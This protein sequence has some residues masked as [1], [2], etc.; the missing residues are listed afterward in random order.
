MVKS[1]TNRIEEPEVEAHEDVEGGA[2]V[3][4]ALDPD[5]V[6]IAQSLMASKRQTTAAV[7]ELRAKL[8]ELDEESAGRFAGLLEKVQQVQ[9][10]LGLLRDRAEE[11]REEGNALSGEFAERHE[12]VVASVQER[13]QAALRDIA[14]H[15]EAVREDARGEAAAAAG[16]DE[17]LAGQLDAVSS[18]VAAATE[19]LGVVSANVADV[20]EAAA[21]RHQEVG[22][23]TREC[24]V[25]IA[26]QIEGGLAKA[27]KETTRLK[28]LIEQRSAQQIKQATGVAEI[29]RGEGEQRQVEHAAVV[30]ALESSGVV[31]GELRAVVEQLPGQAAAQDERRGV[32]HA[33]VVEALESSGVV[34]GELREAVGELPARVEGEG[35]QTRE[36]LDGLVGE[37]SGQVESAR[38][39][40]AGRQLRVLELLEAAAEVDAA[41]GQTLEQAA[42]QLRS[43]GDGLHAVL[44]ERFEQLG[45]GVAEAVERDVAAADALGS[46]RADVGALGELL[47]SVPEQVERSVREIVVSAEQLHASWAG[48]VSALTRAVER[49]TEVFRQKSSASEHARDVAVFE[50]GKRLARVEENHPA[51]L[52]ASRP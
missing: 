13:V 26:D 8:E 10:N 29:V 48:E 19:T 17:Q 3:T 35:A 44:H 38:S 49:M 15:I 25:R 1:S 5:A 30:E 4:V 32:E 46:V 51:A 42:G 24:R 34:L 2:G 7:S 28:R 37:L 45:R 9:H 47:R 33:A 20:Q 6:Q 43:V 21:A 18:S 31:L 52:E 23:W 27:F 12:A 50:L 39:A 14:A 41:H 40:G 36:L 11:L 16:R 22:Q